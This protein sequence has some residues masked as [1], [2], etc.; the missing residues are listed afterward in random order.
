MTKKIRL[1]TLERLKYC[2]R[3]YEDGGEIVNVREMSNWPVQ[4][5]SH[6]E[7]WAKW[8]ENLTWNYSYQCL[9]KSSVALDKKERYIFLIY[10][11]RIINIINEIKKI[12]STKQTITYTP[13]EFI[14]FIFSNKKETKEVNINYYDGEDTKGLIPCK[15]CKGKTKWTQKQTRSADEPMT[16]FLQCM[17][18]TCQYQWRM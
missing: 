15:K 18:P 12:N 7:V 3:D 5:Q 14:D 2:L 17:N 13:N 4:P 16:V 11:S 1:Q 10:I 6:T 9:S 8:I